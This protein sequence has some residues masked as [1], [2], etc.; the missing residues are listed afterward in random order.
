MALNPTNKTVSENSEKGQFMM[1]YIKEQDYEYLKGK[2]HDPEKPY[3]SLSRFHRRDEYF[4][5]NS[6]MA[7]EAILE[8]ILEQDAI[9]EH[10]PHPVRKANAFAFVL[11]NTRISCDAR[12]RFP[13]IHMVDRPLNQTVIAKWKSEVF[14]ELIPEVEKRRAALENA[15]IV[16]IWPDYDHS[17]PVWDRVFELK[18]HVSSLWN[19]ECSQRNR[20]VSLMVSELLILRSL[21]L[22]K[23]WQNWQAKHPEVREW[24]KRFHEFSQT[25]R[26]PFMKFC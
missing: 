1:E 3:D 16:T 23:D 17:V 21:I 8:G 10:L 15:G 5:E 9:S 2:Y 19:R 13:A 24:Q 25:L 4:A 20:K 7:P 14:S 12:D 26:Q 11:K 6:G 22:S 18:Q